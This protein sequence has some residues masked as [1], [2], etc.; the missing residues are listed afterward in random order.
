ML[1]RAPRPISE[2]IEGLKGLV[3]V[4]RLMQKVEGKDTCCHRTQPNKM[5]E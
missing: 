5:L 1:E 2:Y 3:C 4:R